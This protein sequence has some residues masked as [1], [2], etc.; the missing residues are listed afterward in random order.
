M[1]GAGLTGIAAWLDVAGRRLLSAWGAPGLRRRTFFQAALIGLVG[2]LVSYVFQR[3]TGGLFNLFTGQTGGLAAGA[4]QL[5]IARRLAVPTLGG[6][7]A[8][9]LLS[10]GV[11]WA[12]GA[13]SREFMEA[14]VL[15]DGVIPVRPTLARCA[16]SLV[17]IASGCSIGR[18]GPMVQLAA[19]AGS[20]LGRILGL[21][22]PRLRLMVACGVAA[23]I[24][25]AYRAPVAGSLFVAEIVLGSL[26]MAS[27][28]P[29]LMASMVASSI[30]RQLMGSQPLYPVAVSPLGSPLNFL[31]LLALGL[32]AGVMGPLFLRGLRASERA[33]AALGLPL[34]LRLA[35]GGLVVG[36]ISTLAPQV[37]GNGYAELLRLLHQDWALG[38]LALVLGCKLLATFASVGSGAVGGVFTPTLLL[39][40]GI[41]I[42]CQQLCFS[43]WPVWT[44]PGQIFALVGMGSF[45]AATTHAPLMAMLLIFEYTLDYDVIAPLMLACTA[46]YTLAVGIDRRSVYTEHLSR[47]LPGRAALVAAGRV[48][49]LIDPAPAQATVK[50]KLA[51]LVAE[52]AGDPAQVLFVVDAAGAYR[53][54]LA[55]G[56]LRAGLDAGHTTLGELLP[57]TP[58]SETTLTPDSSLAQ[59][60]GVF[61]QI[62]WAQL[63]VVEEETG[64]FLGSVARADL[65]LCLSQGLP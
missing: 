34:T 45:L 19:L 26:R 63:A 43:L 20:R 30:S 29:L 33:F 53:G 61:M 58:A 36:I 42:L 48:A 62:P 3:A 46:A 27:F 24:A 28:G 15:D 12:R 4:G 8:G 38:G 16:S 17:S 56:A 6:A 40:G 22:A 23:G 13:P 50:R 44:A 32:M 11:R 55:P 59:A 2:A 41:G 35:A 18:E 37:W 60:A 47:R 9:A 5:S 25:S 49:D 57:P 21:P 1:A 14:I 54:A 64:L 31:P 10:A 39:G 51:D 7:L 65:L 52:M